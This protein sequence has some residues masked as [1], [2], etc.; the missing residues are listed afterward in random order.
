MA[1]S[2]S[3]DSPLLC[4][5]G[6][7]VSPRQGLDHRLDFRLQAGQTIQLAGPSGSGK[8]TVLRVLARLRSA[9][10]GELRWRGQLAQQVP[11]HDWRS[12]IAY[13]PQQ[14]VLFE[15]TVAD[16]LA[17]PFSARRCAAA[18]DPKAAQALLREVGLAGY[19]ERDARK[20]SGGE[21]MRVALCRALAR[22][23]EVLLADELFAQLDQHSAVQCAQVLRALLAAGAALVLVAHHLPP[24]L[25][26]Y[27]RPTELWLENAPAVESEAL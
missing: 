14:P 12:R 8:T 10:G 19:L 6:L 24:P 5:A 27:L 20:L 7:Q 11:A 3:N 18:Y 16:N 26:D 25:A 17:L 15:G 21:G 2:D 22:Q 9:E 1:A 23:P 13:L 4:A